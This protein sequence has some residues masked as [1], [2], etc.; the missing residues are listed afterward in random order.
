MPPIARSFAAIMGGMV[1][2]VTVVSLCDLAAG[3]LHPAPPGFDL[4][5]MAQAEAH[6]AAAPTSALLMVLLG[7][8]LGPFAGGLVAS[9]VAAGNG[10]MYVWV[11]TGVLYVATIM[12]LMVVPHPTWMV[13]GALLGVPL[14]GWLAARLAPR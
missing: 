13:A 7:W 8:M 6:A 4:R 9:R 1:I 14:A 11:I 3:A 12:N 5:D 10:R 2:A